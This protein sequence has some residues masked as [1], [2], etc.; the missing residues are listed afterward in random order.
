LQQRYEAEKVRY[1]K[2]EL[3]HEV[4]VPEVCRHLPNGMVIDI[5]IADIE[6]YMQKFLSWLPI[7]RDEELLL[8]LHGVLSESKVQKPFKDIPLKEIDLLDC[9]FFKHLDR[10]GQQRIVGGLEDLGS[11]VPKSLEELKQDFKDLSPLDQLITKKTPMGK[12]EA[13]RLEKE[14]LMV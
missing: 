6:E 9:H 10:E 12:R 1:R 14:K 4:T 13:K 3:L 5:P 8:L 11:R 7:K 2:G